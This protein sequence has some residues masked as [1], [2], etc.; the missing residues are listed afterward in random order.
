MSSTDSQLKLRYGATDI[1]FVS[2]D[3]RQEKIFDTV[4]AHYLRSNEKEKNEIEAHNDHLQE[5]RDEMQLKHGL[6]VQQ[7]FE[8]KKEKRECDC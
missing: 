3:K 7:E 1:I 6:L 8:I 4:W 5:L 2:L